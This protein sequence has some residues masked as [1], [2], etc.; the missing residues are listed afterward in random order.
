[1]NLLKQYLPESPKIMQTASPDGKIHKHKDGFNPTVK[2]TGEEFTFK[3]TRKSKTQQIDKYE[4][5]KAID[6]D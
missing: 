2:W 6:Q 3:P 1:M 5:E 4:T